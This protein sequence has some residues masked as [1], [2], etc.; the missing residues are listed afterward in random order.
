MEHVTRFLSEPPEQSY[1]PAVGYRNRLT[2]TVF[3]LEAFV[4]RL[5]ELAYPG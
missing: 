4:E 5:V 2:G 3:D 1:E